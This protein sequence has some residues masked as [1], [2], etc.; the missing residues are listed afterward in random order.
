V[1]VHQFSGGFGN[2]NGFVGILDDVLVTTAAGLTISK[3]KG[4]HFYGNLSFD[5]GGKVNF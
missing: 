1:D 4:K 2:V 5:A 3:V